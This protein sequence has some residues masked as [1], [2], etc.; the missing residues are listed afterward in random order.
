MKA[1]SLIP[2][3][4][5]ASTFV[6]SEEA[7]EHISIESH[8]DAEDVTKVPAAKAFASRIHHNAL[9]IFESAQDAVRAQMTIASEQ[10]SK[11]QKTLRDQ[12]LEEA[13]KHGLDWHSPMKGP[14]K[15][16][17]YEIIAECKYTTKLASLINEREDLVQLLNGTSRSFT[18][19]APVDKAFKFKQ[20]KEPSKEIIKD[21]L[22]YHVSG[23]FYPAGRVL[24]GA[25]VPTLLRGTGLSKTPDRDTQRI[26]HQ[27]GLR[28]LTVNFYSR[29]IA[30]DIVGFATCIFTVAEADVCPSSAP[31]GSYMVYHR[32]YSR[33]FQEQR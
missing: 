26:S 3:A 6:I 18:V 30:I 9:D 12:E 25:T 14:P 32:F 7:S 27:L 4:A 2:L 31:T 8:R 1:F 15:K 23:D 13:V 22:S 33:Q 10:F 19:F 24:A 20:H 17:V 5:C 29:I 28:G 21:L 16:T 11:G